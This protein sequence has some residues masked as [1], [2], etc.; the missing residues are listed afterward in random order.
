MFIK[1]ILPEIAHI[2][3]KIEVMCES[4]HIS[5]NELTGTS[6]VVVGSEES[7]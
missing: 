3:Y 2:L 6:V 1:I 5:Y 4:T 7:V